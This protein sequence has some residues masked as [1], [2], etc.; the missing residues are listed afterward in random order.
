MINDVDT[1]CAWHSFPFP[2]L[3]PESK[4]DGTWG[5]R[6][7][8]QR[9]NS[10]AVAKVCKDDTVFA[11]LPLPPHQLSPHGTDTCHWRQRELAGLWLTWCHLSPQGETT[12]IS[13]QL[14]VSKVA[15]SSLPM[16]N[17]Q[18]GKCKS[19]PSHR[20]QRVTVLCWVLGRL[21]LLSTGT[22]CFGR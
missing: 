2:P 18:L 20:I 22:S 11:S 17:N 10:W 21:I 14:A 1:D 7:H 9:P 19:K 3:L 16:K 6:G 4:G 13:P 15:I 5:Q 12:Q 8:G